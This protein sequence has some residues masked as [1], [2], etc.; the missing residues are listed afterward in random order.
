MERKFY[1][2]YED[3]VQSACDANLGRELTEI[4]LKRLFWIF[5]SN[6]AFSSKIYGAIVDASEEATNSEGWEE[7]DKMYKDI[8][9]EE[10]TL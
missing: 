5:I 10:L 8:P 3:L 6:D 4:E 7:Y 1:V 9:L 2:I